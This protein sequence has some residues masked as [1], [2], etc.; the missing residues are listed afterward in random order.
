MH[1]DQQTKKKTPNVK[2]ENLHYESEDSESKK[3]KKHSNM[4]I[5]ASSNFL[6][7][8]NRNKHKILKAG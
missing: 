5:V 4:K 7:N 6:N 1:Y 8:P 2:D 3:K